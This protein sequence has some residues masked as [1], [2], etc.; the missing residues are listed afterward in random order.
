M[1]LAQNIHA[2]VDHLT[3]IRNGGQAG[4]VS[5]GKSCTELRNANITIDMAYPV[6]TLKSRKVSYALLFAEAH[7]ILSGSDKLKDIVKWCPRM[8]EFSDD[9]KVLRGAYGP[10]FRSQVSHVARALADDIGTRQAVMTLWNR[11]PRSSRDIPCTLSMQFLIRD[12]YLHAI[13]SMRSSDAWLGLPY[14]IF[15]FTMMTQYVRMMLPAPISVGMLYI[16][17]GSAHIY[18]TDDDKVSKVLSSPKNFEV[19]PAMDLYSIEYPDD[20]LECLRD[21]RDHPR[22][23]LR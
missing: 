14:D 11:C 15:S 4:V 18:R 6:L 12:F 2:W 17:M 5:R 21:N 1:S 3:N 22:D 13:V 9:G 23:F 16:N 10:R 7:W 19:Y 20:L 8:R